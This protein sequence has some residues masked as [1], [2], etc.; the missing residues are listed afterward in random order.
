MKNQETPPSAR[1][2]FGQNV[3]R[4]RRLKEMSQEELAFRA[5]IS[6]TYL[7][8]VERGE[9]NISVDNMEALAIALEME[10]PDLMRISLLSLPSEDSR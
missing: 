7:S 1:V 8:E 6:R 4:V 3:R 10:L 2:I 5:D 9:R